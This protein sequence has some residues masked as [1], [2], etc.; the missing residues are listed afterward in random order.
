MVVFV[1]TSAIYALANAGDPNHGRSVEALRSALQ[2]GEELLTH[3]YVVVES[4]TLLHR[5]LG[6][7]AVSRFVREANAF[8]IRWVD[9]ILHR[10]AAE[11][12]SKRRG[13][14][15]LVDEVSF[16]VM[17]EAGIQHALAFDQDFLAE[18]F[19]LYPG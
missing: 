10:T 15:S 16:L 19:H 1:D 7:I 18:G 4:A 8:R 12:F 17:R 14:V 9:D 3:N 11:R 5:R 13:Q 6:W 2:V